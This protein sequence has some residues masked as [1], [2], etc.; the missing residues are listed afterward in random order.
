MDS[1]HRVVWE[2]A[3]WKDLGRFLKRDNAL[4]K[5]QIGANR[6]ERGVGCSI[7]RS[8]SSKV[9]AIRHSVGILGE[10]E[11][12][13]AIMTATVNTSSTWTHKERIY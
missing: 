8:S 3:Q 7:R 2:L 5:G 13:N 9:T 11:F 6:E 12:V 10:Q 4:I 1:D